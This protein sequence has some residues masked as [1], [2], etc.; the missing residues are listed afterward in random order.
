[1]FKFKFSIVFVSDQTS[2]LYIKVRHRSE[3]WLKEQEKLD[4]LRKSNRPLAFLSLNFHKR[5]LKLWE[6]L[7]ALYYL[8]FSYIILYFILI[9]IRPGLTI[10]RATAFTFGA[11]TSKLSDRNLSDGGGILYTMKA[12]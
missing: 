11:S 7:K 8:W 4:W 2:F 6:S 12:K 3:V 10:A 5:K 9:L 1:M